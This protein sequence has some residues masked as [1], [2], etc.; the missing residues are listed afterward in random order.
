VTAGGFPQNYFKNLACFSACEN[1]RQPTT[2]YHPFT[3]KTPR[4][5]TH[6][7]EAP[8]QKTPIN[9]KNHPFPPPTNFSE[10]NRFRMTKWTG[11]VNG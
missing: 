1:D 9:P 11:R 8:S 4:K 6:C 2:I 10:I 3:T 5:N 7:S